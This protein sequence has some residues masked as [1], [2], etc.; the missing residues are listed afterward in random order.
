MTTCERLSHVYMGQPIVAG[1]RNDARREPHQSQPRS[2]AQESSRL[3]AARRAWLRRPK[4]PKQANFGMKKTTP[5]YISGDSAKSE[6]LKRP[7]V[8]RSRAAA[9][10]EHAVAAR[11]EEP[12]ESRTA[13]ATTA[14][15]R[16]RRRPMVITSSSEEERLKQPSQ[17]GSAREKGHEFTRPA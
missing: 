12:E 16:L 10:A 4:A 17:E 6:H 15:T 14:R 2:K 13:S 5:P 9:A 8:G 3:L 11:S 7:G 1:A